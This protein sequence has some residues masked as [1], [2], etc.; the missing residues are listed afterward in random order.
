[1]VSIRARIAIVLS[2]FGIATLVAFAAVLRAVQETQFRTQAREAAE[3]EVRAL[4]GQI[5]LRIREAEIT[6][7]LTRLIRDPASDR[8][9]IPIATARLR[10]L[11]EGVPDYV[12]VIARDGRLIY[13]SYAARALR[14]EDRFA[15]DSIVGTIA[16]GAQAERDASGEMFIVR[17]P[18]GSV[19]AVPLASGGELL[20]FAARASTRVRSIDRVV[21]GRVLRTPPPQ[22][23]AF[24]APVMV[25]IPVVVLVAY[26]GALLIVRLAFGPIETLIN[27]IE[28]VGDGRS[29]HRRVVPEPG[30]P[31]QLT[32]LS[33]TVNAMLQRLETSFGALRRFTA[34]ASHELKTPLAV[35]RADVERAMATQGH[36]AEQLVALEEALAETA[37]M[38]DLVDS[39]LTLARADEGR[40]EIHRE[41][42]DLEALA[43]EVYET[44][45]L[46]GERTHLNVTMMPPPQ[47]T[48]P[49]DRGRLRQLFLNLVTNAIKYTPAG[50]EV[51]LKLERVDGTAHFSV[52]DTGIGIA[53][54]DVEHVFDRFWRADRVRSRVG[55]RGG[56]GLGL[57][58]SQYIAQAHGG[59]LTVQSRL[60]RGST[61][62]VTLP[63]EVPPE[64][65][66]NV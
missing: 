5:A 57:A 61:F 34:D 45:L 54:A 3:A 36:R 48:A 60:G 11:L 22:I 39:L 30:T 42:V 55:E 24:V 58:I 32:R 4:A 7:T 65:A 17:V 2:V 38:A 19:H 21:A 8:D 53:A 1:V 64:D 15:L 26:L 27:D 51:E 6:D 29:L 46:L 37:R 52:R 28:A 49:G 16:V 23:V 25:F 66:T 62:T 41:P 56:F 43:R 59:T 35:M 50:G 20:L 13:N 18:G 33:E 63:L 40:F 14:D 44:A 47:I 9:S 31:E 12:Y 10:S